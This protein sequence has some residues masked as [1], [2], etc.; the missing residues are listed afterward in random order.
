MSTC[1]YFDLNHSS[2]GFDHINRNAPVLIRTP[3]LTRFEPAQYWGGGP[4]GNSVV[5]NPPFCLFLAFG[6]NLFE[7]I[8]AGVALVLLEGGCGC[9]WRMC[10]IAYPSVTSAVYV[11]L[12]SCTQMQHPYLWVR[13]S[14]VYVCVY[15][16]MSVCV[17]I[18]ACMTLCTCV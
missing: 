8:F 16:R 9:T 12:R 1:S 15:V 10:T 3:K 4:P 7:S 6:L 17:Y 18:Y 14:S 5:L 13:M 2:F 11:R